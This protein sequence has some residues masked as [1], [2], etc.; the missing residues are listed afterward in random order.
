MLF[1]AHGGSAET[2]GIAANGSRGASFII[3]GQSAHTAQLEQGI[4]A[5]INAAKLVLELQKLGNE[6]NQRT[7][8]LPGTDSVMRSRFSVNKI[9]G[10]VAHNY[11][12]DRCEVEVDRR[13][14]PGETEEEIDEEYSNVILKAKTK[15]PEL[16][17][18]YTILQGN[19]VSVAPADSLL[20]EE[21]Q[22][23]AKQVI[24]ITPKPIG[25]SHSSDH[26]L[27]C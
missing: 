11:V 22:K 12:P 21:I 16:N 17:V 26:G 8:N 10:Y 6:V 7:Y 4:N 18:D 23:A 19:L 20:V 24:G 9:Y 15:Y 25:G 27:V 5:V 13:Y 1:Y 3:K 14:T 2:I